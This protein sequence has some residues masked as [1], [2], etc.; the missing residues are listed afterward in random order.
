MIIVAQTDPDDLVHSHPHEAL[1]NTGP[2]K[3]RFLE[4]DDDD[5]AIMTLI[6]VG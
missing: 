6:N 1:L 4:I 3:H 5:D 2:P